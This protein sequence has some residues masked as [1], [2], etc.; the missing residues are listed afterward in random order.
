MTTGSVVAP[1]WWNSRVPAFH[2]DPAG[3]RDH[4]LEFSAQES[5]HLRVRRIRP[6]EVIDAIDGEGTGYRVRLV[7]LEGD[8]AI[9]EILE[10]CV[11]AGESVCHLHLA[12]AMIKGQRFDTIVE[13]ATEIGVHAIHPLTTARS[14]VKGEGKLERWQRVALAAAKQCG[15]SR[16]PEISAAVPLKDAAAGF[17]A[18]G[19]AILV[20]DPRAP[21]SLD[22]IWAEAQRVAL[23]VG[24]EGGFDEN[25]LDCLRGYSA[26]SF[27]WGHRILRADTAAIVLSALVLD[28]AQRAVSVTTN[29]TSQGA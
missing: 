11:E 18:S 22:T 12:A 19:T 27:V 6:D 23:F 7:S 15:R 14:V 17:N 21:Q 20:A 5:H 29:L 1:A 25:E 4:R 3:I 26:R 28:Q 13:K 16:I 10:V 24:P 2:I 8:T 9:G